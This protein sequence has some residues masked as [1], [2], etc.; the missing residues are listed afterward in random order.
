MTSQ[1]VSFGTKTYLIQVILTRLHKIQAVRKYR[2][3]GCSDMPIIAVNKLKALSVNI[4]EAAGVRADVAERVS[5]HLVESNLSGMDSHGVMRLASYIQWVKE[6]MVAT[7]NRVE[8][9]Q[10]KG[11]TVLL[12]G[13]STFGPV[14]AARASE[15]ADRKS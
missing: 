4:F 9:L 5:S 12:D 7:D 15:I 8:I 13:H 6:G 14:A 11:A 10:D 3:E 1:V 2:I